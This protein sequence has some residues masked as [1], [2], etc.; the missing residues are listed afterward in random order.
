[1]GAEFYF[2][3]AA[4]EGRP[5]E[6]LNRLRSQIFADGEFNGAHLNPRSPE[7]A[8]TLTEPEGTRSILDISHISETPD[9][10]AASPFS[11]EELEDYFGSAKP[12]LETVRAQRSAAADSIG[13]GTARYL[14]A[15][16]QTGNPS[17]Y[18]FM[19]YSFD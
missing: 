5:L 4:Y 19:G 3:E 9:Y 2:Y 13:R 8:V 1:M 6:A 10:F 14:V 18:I 11:V 12:T 17:H 15:Y 7:E 16:D